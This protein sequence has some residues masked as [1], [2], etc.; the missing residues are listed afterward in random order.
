MPNSFSFNKYSL[1]RPEKSPIFY[2]YIITI[3]GTVGVIASIPGQTI[4]VSAFTNPVMKALGL[5]RDQFSIAYTIGT[6][7]SSFFLTQAGRWYDRFGARWVALFS[8]IGLATALV[9][10]SGSVTMSGY[11]QNLLNTSSSL[12]PILLMIVLFAFVRFSGQG[13][14]T[15]VSRNM[16]M[17]WFDALRGR[18]N[19]ISSVVVSVGF[20]ASP[21][22]INIFIEDHG[23]KNTW[24]IMAFILIGFSL[25]VLQFYRDKPE[26]H[27][28]LPDGKK[29]IKKESKNKDAREARQQ[30][31][32]TEAKRTR[33]FWMYSLMLAFNGYYI[34]GLTFHIESVFVESGFDKATAFSIFLPVSG[35]SFLFSFGGNAISDYTK[36]KYLLYVM[37]GGGVIGTLGLIF[38]GGA[39]G[40]YVLVAG[41]GITSGMFAVLIAVAWPRFFGRKHLGEVAGKT[42]SMIVLAS[43]LGPSMFSYS[44]SLFGSYKVVAFA[45]LAF[46]IVL[47][48]LSLKANNPQVD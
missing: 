8:T 28:L 48:F 19:A 9:L 45:S 12:V 15:L 46:L 42:M 3:I 27:G 24:L 29:I 14:L 10:C 38:L 7:I 22:L 40:V 44:L 32:L 4:G 47:V 25:I 2:G 31:T 43:A 17:K 35:V 6:I 18:V 36:L 39:F 26:D 30:Y 20:S 11:I 37:I 1:V 16:I 41:L 23:W 21:L 34:T 13:V 33:A 5:N